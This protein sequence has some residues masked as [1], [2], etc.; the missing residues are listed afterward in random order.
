M[1]SYLKCTKIHTHISYHLVYSPD[2]YGSRGQ[3]TPK[4]GDGNSESPTWV[5]HLLAPQD[6]L[7]GSWDGAGARTQAWAPSYVL[8]ASQDSWGRHSWPAP[9]PV[10]PSC[11]PSG[12]V[13][14]SCVIPPLGIWAGLS[15]PAVSCLLLDFGFLSVLRLFSLAPGPQESYVFFPPAQTRLT[16]STLHREGRSAHSTPAHSVCLSAWDGRGTV[17]IPSA[18]QGSS[19]EQFSGWGRGG[20]CSLDSASWSSWVSLFPAAQGCVDRKS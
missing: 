1:K 7:A 19:V 6:T 17:I 16:G 20:Q 3:A 5:C 11:V 18:P 13:C 12:P 10:P 4:L 8:L 9:A 15:R 14:V 2:A